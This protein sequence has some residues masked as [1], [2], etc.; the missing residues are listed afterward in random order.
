MAFF[1]SLYHCLV[2]C[3]FSWWNLIMPLQIYLNRREGPSLT[4]IQ[5]TIARSGNHQFYLYGDLSPQNREPL[6]LKLRICPKTL[7]VE[8]A[9]VLIWSSK[10]KLWKRHWLCR[11]LSWPMKLEKYLL[12]FRYVDRSLLSWFFDTELD[13]FN[14]IVLYDLCPKILFPPL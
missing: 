5:W 11:V 6:P 8:V 2:L 7:V 14:E 10:R 3:F 13:V 9:L 1:Y 4:Q 12:L